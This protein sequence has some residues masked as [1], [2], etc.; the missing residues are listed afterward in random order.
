MIVLKKGVRLLGIQ[1][2]IVLVIVTAERIYDEIGETLR[3]T[4][5]VDGQHMRASLHYVGAAIDFG[6]PES[7]ELNVR[8]RL[9]SALGSDFDVVEEHDHIHVEWQPK[10][11]L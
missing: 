2:P 3:I 1:V 9:A 4:S 8:Q 11:A 7:R 10:A 6:L 5:V